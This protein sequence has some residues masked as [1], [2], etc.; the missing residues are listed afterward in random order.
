MDKYIFPKLRKFS[1]F[2]ELVKEKETYG[3]FEFKFGK[4]KPFSDLMNYNRVFVLAE[5]GY[6]KTRCLK[7]LVKDSAK[8]SRKSIFLDIKQIGADNIEDFIKQKLVCAD[9]ISD[10]F[11]IQTSSFFT[12]SNFK[13]SN[14]ENITVCLDALDEVDQNIFS[15]VVE[16]IRQF[17]RRYTKVSLFISCRIHFFRKYSDLFLL[18]G[19]SYVHLAPLFQSEIEE[20][21]LD[22]GVKKE[23]VNMIFHTLDFKRD[24][25][26]QTPRYLEFLASF[27]L[28]RGIKEV[29]GLKVS[30]LFEFFIY[31]KLEAENK[32]HN[33]F[34][35]VQV[36]TIKRVLEKLALLMEIH[37]V[38]Q[39]KEDDLMTFFDGID[40]GLT[41]G[42]LQSA[43]LQLF[44]ERG[45]IKD[46]FNND[47]GNY[48]EFENTEFQEYLAAKEIS[49]LGN[50]NRALYSLSIDPAL[51]EI[52]P[53]WFNTLRFVVN[54]NPSIFDYILNL[55]NISKSSIPT[56]EYHHFIS[57]IDPNCIGGNGKK[58]VFEEVFN[59][60]KEVAV[61]L[62]IDLVENLAYFFDES[63][64]KL[65][66][67]VVESDSKTNDERTN[68]NKINVIKLIGFIVERN[69]LSRADVSFWKNI[70]LKVALDKKKD[71][72]LRRVSLATLRRFGEKEILGKVKC[73][74]NEKNKDL[75]KEIIYLYGSLDSSSKE[76]VEVFANGTKN[77]CYVESLGFLFRADVNN[78]FLNSFFGLLINDREFLSS[79]L[80]H[81]SIF[82]KDVQCFTDS[83]SDFF[84]S[85]LYN[86]IL[87]IIEES[88]SSERYWNAERSVFL[89]NIAR[90]A[91]DYNKGFLGELLDKVEKSEGL[92]GSIFGLQYIFKNALVVENVREF[93][94]RLK[95]IEHG[96]RV[97]LWTLQSAQIDK[98]DVYL[99]GKKY[100]SNEYKESDNYARK[101]KR[102]QSR[103]DLQEKERFNKSIEISLREI[104]DRKTKIYHFNA[105]IEYLRLEESKQLKVSSKQEDALKKVCRFIFGKFDPKDARVSRRE[106]GVFLVH[107]WLDIFGIS[108]EVAKHLNAVDIVDKNIRKRLIRYIP[109]A[110]EHQLEGIFLLVNDI[111]K[112]EIESLF[113]QFKKDADIWK[114]RARSI[115]KV[116]EKFQLNEYGNLIKDFVDD[117]SFSLDDRKTSLIAVDDI[118][119]DQKFLNKT[120]KKYKNKNDDQKKLAEKS[121][122]ILI[123]KYESLDAIR[124][125][126]N[127]LEK[128]AFSFIR[129]EGV[130]SISDREHEI[131]SKEFASPIF[132]IAKSKP[133]QYMEEIVKLADKSL[134]I[135]N[136]GNEFHAYAVYLWEIIMAY[137]ER[138]KIHRTYSPLVDFEKFI[139]ENLSRNGA[140]FLSG[141]FQNI[142]AEYAA[143]IGKPQDFNECVKKYN[144]L[145]NLKFERVTDTSELRDTIL[146]IIS[147]D[148]ARWVEDEGALKVMETLTKR[149]QGEDLI[150]KILLTQFTACALK[151]GFVENEI[152]F[153]REEE[154]LDGDKTDYLV[155]YG[156]IGP[157]VVEIKRTDNGNVANKKYRGK[158]RKYMQGT[159]SDYCIFLIF[160]IKKD[161]SLRKKVN[162]AKEVYTK[163]FPFIKVVGIDCVGNEGFLE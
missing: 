57:K 10:D 107:P 117:S 132:D 157:V 125:R 122:E 86:N 109:Y 59:Y 111:K 39:I 113:S 9:E 140:N 54:L 80:E 20:F 29:S 151:R 152:L 143:Y 82:N 161:D 21:L 7:E 61:Y 91:A 46:G 23:D 150:Q 87:G 77:D 17:S 30:D 1:S 116:I 110:Y 100:F 93:I 45:I 60:Y 147:K 5:P 126:L 32:K 16:N 160:K 38:S 48:F 78:E 154:F 162:K 97:A 72:S 127:E 68:I 73:I 43:P 159:K 131:D 42:F 13:L 75:S 37:Q 141:M 112:N 24:L 121:N 83:L 53:S 62:D 146:E 58:I 90:A 119:S 6:G 156:F 25:I 96:E 120:F 134:K 76:S 33:Q 19:F 158:L 135:Y 74:L 3:I 4:S 71:V 115:V 28:E 40:S 11:D 149:N 98:E 144:T 15:K 41:L 130:Y 66:K 94:D 14:N 31:R 56:K 114:Y 106:D 136:K 35:I 81:E 85:E 47:L 84:D 139:L 155:S 50:I 101:Y 52:Y 55:K 104:G 8:S 128:R 92:Q 145:I 18:D 163:D 2:N 44:F 79:L 65:L 133:K 63:Q 103:F 51:N 118:F 88:F 142:K 99:E 89:N 148:I 34:T 70:L 49:R 67:E 22:R 95:K 12:T 26:I 36:N 108:L 69:I 137:L 129:S 138:Q 124:W 102:Q 27:L 123:T 64:I 105:L 153:R